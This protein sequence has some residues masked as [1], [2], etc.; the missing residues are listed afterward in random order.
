M[1]ICLC[2]PYKNHVSLT[3][4]GVGKISFIGLKEMK[5]LCKFIDVFVAD[6]GSFFGLEAGQVQAL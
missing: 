3:T 1:D 5:C 2:G 4:N 6:F